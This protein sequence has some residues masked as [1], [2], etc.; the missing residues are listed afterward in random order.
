[1]TL[2]NVHQL[3]KSFGSATLFE[4]LSFGIDEREHIGLV[5]PNGAGK[6]TLLKLLEGSIEPD[7]GQISKKRGLRLGFL[8][9]NPQFKPQ[10][11]IIDAILEKCSDPHESMGLAYEIITQLQLNQFGD[12]ALVE[13]LSGGWQKRVALARE[14]VL[15]PELLL[16]D[17]P[18]NHLDVTSI[19]W[20]ENYLKSVRYAFVMIT[21]DRLFLQRTVDRIMDLDKRNPNYIL[22][23]R[24]TYSDYIETKE[25]ELAALKRQERVQKNNLRREVEWLRRG[26]IARQTK[27]TAR[28]KS[29]GELADSLE[30][31]KEKNTERISGIEF[32]KLDRSPQ[33]LIEVIDVSK[34]YNDKRLFE[35]L[36]ILIS[37][38]TR[39]S[40]LGDN[41]CGKSTL[42]KILIEQIQPDTGKIKAADKLQ[43]SY[44]EQSKET[45]DRKKSVLKNIC[46]EG[47]Y[48]N[49]CGQ[50]VHVRSYLDRF[51]FFGKKA[52]LPV[53]KLSGGE[54]ARLRIAQLMLQQAQV[55]V[56]D[57]PTND[58]D[59]D[60]LEV[61][62]QALKEFNG[63]VILVTHDRFFMDAVSNQILAFPPD[64]FPDK[65]LKMFASY[66][67]WEE[68][69]KTE[70]EKL[71]YAPTKTSPSAK[72]TK[73]SAQKLSFKEKF[74][75][76]NME[77]TIQALESN[78]AELNK[79]LETPEYISDHKK[80]MD[81]NTKL[82]DLQSQLELKYQRWSELEEK[83]K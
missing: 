37:P 26:A 22:N 56:L 68:W 73:S 15:E 79:L 18:T 75:L 41:G 16:L 74:E 48:V 42:I 55:L 5:G 81:T 53:E 82:A 70:T 12:Q 38:K 7:A 17:E 69:F 57:E 47:D 58:L 36:D 3:S 50:Y 83:T 25:Q 24:G 9:Q 21:H 19:L 1:M 27:Q 46:P 40:L 72:I 54:Q 30:N 45:L 43:I 4:G 32:G 62:E 13:T 60:T 10:Q 6:S 63:A 29:A 51:L 11:N 78:I 49:F 76:D 31:L 67:Q 8:E 34:S 52:D 80:L 66:F 61:L 77:S 23:I 14:L 59:A 64:S 2:I 35:N 28:I 20:L 33:K 65:K 39:L 71:R 44:F